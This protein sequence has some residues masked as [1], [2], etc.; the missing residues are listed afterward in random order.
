MVV[1]VE[2]RRLH[3]WNCKQVGHLGKVCPQKAA[4]TVQQPKEAEVNTATNATPE[5]KTNRRRRRRKNGEAPPKAPALKVIVL[6]SKTQNT[7]PP[8]PVIQRTPSAE[9]PSTPS[10]T[11]QETH[12]VATP[13]KATSLRPN[14]RTTRPPTKHPWTLLQTL[15]KK[16]QWRWPSQKIL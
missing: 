10:S 16:G 13:K 5:A 7:P 4:D 12:P 15:K 3:C 6:K 11:T 2:G 9:T 8:S 14:P 1:V